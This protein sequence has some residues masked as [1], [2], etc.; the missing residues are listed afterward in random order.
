MDARLGEVVRLVAGQCRREHTDQ[1]QV[2]VGRRAW[3]EPSDVLNT[4]RFE[5]F[6]ASLRRNRR[7]AA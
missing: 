4:Q 5:A 3:L 6:R 1:P 7:G 2:L